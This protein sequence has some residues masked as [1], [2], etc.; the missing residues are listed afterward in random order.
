MQARS[1]LFKKPWMVPVVPGFA[2]YAA[3]HGAS[4]LRSRRL[5]GS[6]VNFERM[7]GTPD[8]L[9][10]FRDDADLTDNKARDRIVKYLETC[11]PMNKREINEKLAE[12]VQPAINPYLKNKKIKRVGMD[13]DDLFWMFGKIHGLENI[14]FVDEEELNKVRNP[15]DLQILVNNAKRNGPIAS[16]FDNLLSQAH[17]YGDKYKEEVNKLNLYP[18]DKA[19]MLALP[20]FTSRR[21]QGPA[22]Q[23]GQWQ[24]NLFTEIT[25]KTWDHYDNWEVDHEN[26]TSAKDLIPAVR[27]RI[28]TESSEF[29]K[30]LNMYNLLTPTQYERHKE[31]QEWYRS[32][33]NIL[34]DLNEQEGYDLW[35][36]IKNEHQDDYLEDIH[37]GAA[38]S[39]LAKIAETENYAKKNYWNLRRTKLKFMRKEQNPVSKAKIKDLFLHSN[40]FKTKF[41]RELGLYDTQQNM[42]DNEKRFIQTFYDLAIG[43][44]LKLRDEV[45][46]KRDRELIS[47]LRSKDFK[48][49]KE[50]LSDDVI[51]D[52]AYQ[53][54]FSQM[55]PLIDVS[56]YFDYYIGP[57]EVVDEKQR[58]FVNMESFTLNKDSVYPM[59]LSKVGYID[60]GDVPKPNYL[61]STAQEEIYAIPDDDDDE[62]GE[63]EEEEVEV[64]KHPYSET[65]AFGGSEAQE[66]P[67]WPLQKHK[68]NFNEE[69]NIYFDFNERITERFNEHEIDAFMKLMDVKP[70]RNWMDHSSTLTR[71][72]SRAVNDFAQKVDP[73]FHMV[74]EVE[75]ETFERMVLQQHRSGTTVRFA[76]GNTKP[77]FMT[78]ER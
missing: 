53:Y 64:I 17:L 42:I 11:V 34:T 76:V 48:A 23:K 59:D 47:F 44:M 78:S 70:F 41:N 22:P 52:H 33:M 25:G 5:Q 77:R 63:G 72:G 51:A 16:S 8:I 67:E 26:K 1:L 65:D 24:W 18:S 32:L 46:L 7:A 10:K 57:G 29:K 31:Y 49:V 4:Q 73:E 3:Y 37:G 13:K 68:Y 74:G 75:R 14:A 9:S 61:R 36:L 71:L 58:P 19:K 20:F 60:D 54:Q 50:R 28:D 35:H 43:P 55:F 45:G 30:H 39:K 56:D 62:E 2:F 27:E 21:S 12:I 38:E 15:V 6:N 40:E 69:K 66:E